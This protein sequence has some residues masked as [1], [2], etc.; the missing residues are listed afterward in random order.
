MEGKQAGRQTKQKLDLSPTPII[1]L[2]WIIDLMKNLKC[3]IINKRQI[4]IT[5]EQKGILKYDAK[6]KINIGKKLAGL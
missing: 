6:Y 3:I 4:F 2:Q 1:E 5:S